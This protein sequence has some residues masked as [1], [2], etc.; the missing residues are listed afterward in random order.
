M[1]ISVVVEWVLITVIIGLFVSLR[2]LFGKRIYL[3]RNRY[4]TIR[5]LLLPLILIWLNMTSRVV[6]KFSVFPYYLVIISILGLIL[7]AFIRI[8]SFRVMKFFH[9]FFSICF[10]IAILI[11]VLL[12]FY[13]FFL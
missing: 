9:Y 10:I 12:E 6:L 2:Y 5:E 7:I 13:R 4:I 1:D 3:F 8:Q 11:G